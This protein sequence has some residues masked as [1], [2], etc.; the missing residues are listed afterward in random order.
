MSQSRPR[1]SAAR[2]PCRK[3]ASRC[4]RG[5]R[6]CR[7]GGALDRRRRRAGIPALGGQGDPGPAA[8][9]KRRGRS[10]RL[11]RQGI[12]A[13]LRLAFGRA[14]ACGAGERHAGEGGARRQRARMRRALAVEPGCDHRAGALAA[15]A[16]SALHNNCS[17]KHSGFLCGCRHLRIN[18]P[19]YVGADHPYQEMCAGRWRRSPA[20][21]TPNATAA[22]TA[23]RSRPM[24]CRCKTWRPA[25]PGWRPATGLSADRAAAARR[26]FAAC[27]AEPFFVAGSGRADTRLDAG[28]TG[29]H[30]RQDR[31]RR[32]LLRRACPSSG[33]ASR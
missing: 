19:G 8:G 32:R 17:G 27:M 5:V 12:G 28:G 9:R 15:A 18:H 14:G 23:A 29:P 10:L 1:R 22:S 16:P 31:R 20:P 26:L 24:R 3:P 30:L 33:S 11:R 4:R 6:R 25:L 7:Q 2:R 13:G 21:S